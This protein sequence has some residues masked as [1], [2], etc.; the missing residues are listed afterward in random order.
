MTANPNTSH[1]MA[2]FCDHPLFGV[3]FLGLLLSISC[4]WALMEVSEP[5]QGQEVHR[6]QIGLHTHTHAQI[7][8]LRLV[9][10]FRLGL[11]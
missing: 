7:F 6:I 5:P 9:R 11:V 3:P 8:V 4:F 2:F 10:F 1:F